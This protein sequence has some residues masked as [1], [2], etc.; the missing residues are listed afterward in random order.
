M[1]SCIQEVA[2]FPP[3]A[4]CW[5]APV[6]GWAYIPTGILRFA[7]RCK[8]ILPHEIPSC[9]RLMWWCHTLHLFSSLVVM[10]GKQGWG[11]PE[12]DHILGMLWLYHKS[13]KKD[14]G[15]EDVVLYLCHT[16][17]NSTLEMTRKQMIICIFPHLLCKTCICGHCQWS[18]I[19]T[20]YSVEASIPGQHDRWCRVRS[21]DVTSIK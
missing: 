1:I 12:K 5:A 8:W 10:C 2:P 7:L 13:S 4:P 11:Q 17:L 9:F 16:F 18:E 14:M 15:L 19:K 21:N 20:F 6:G 3:Q